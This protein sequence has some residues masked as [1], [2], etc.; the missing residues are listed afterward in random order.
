MMVFEWSDEELV[1]EAIEA[2]NPL[3]ITVRQRWPIAV[4]GY[5]GDGYIPLRQLIEML[6]RDDHTCCIIDP[7]F[8]PHETH[9]QVERDFEGTVWFTVIAIARL[10]LADQATYRSLLAAFEDRR[11]RFVGEAPVIEF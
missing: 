8:D 1:W 2:V 3:K 7:C 5:E 11:E 6:E 9:A 4:I 10:D